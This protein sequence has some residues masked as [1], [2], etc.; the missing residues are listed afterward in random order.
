[1]WNRQSRLIDITL[2]VPGKLYEWLGTLAKLNIPTEF[3]QHKVNADR[4][5]IS[6]VQIGF[7][8]QTK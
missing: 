7:H 3:T 2:A 6:R 1:V 5:R 8:K 4:K